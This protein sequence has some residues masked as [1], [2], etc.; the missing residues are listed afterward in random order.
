MLLPCWLIVGWDRHLRL[1][2]ARGKAALGNSSA[3]AE[4]RHVSRSCQFFADAL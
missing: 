1:D 4:R 3:L 2:D